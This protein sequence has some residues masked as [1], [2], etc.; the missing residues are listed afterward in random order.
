VKVRKH[1]NLTWALILSVYPKQLKDNLKLELHG[2]NLFVYPLGK[3]S[4][5]TEWKRWRKSLPPDQ[6]E[7]LAHEGQGERQQQRER[8]DQGATVR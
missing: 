7:S 6:R 8:C 5:K 4:R 1:E 2:W 3:E